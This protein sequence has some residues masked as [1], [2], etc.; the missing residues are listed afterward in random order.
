MGPKHYP[1]TTLTSLRLQPSTITCCD[2][3]D[4]NCVDIDNTEPPIPTEQSLY[5]IP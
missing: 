5:R 3:S 4:R 2:Q 1:D